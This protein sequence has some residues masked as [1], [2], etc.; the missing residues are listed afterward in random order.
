MT[1]FETVPALGK[2]DS[3]TTTVAGTVHQATPRAA[4]SGCTAWCRAPD[5]SQKGALS[6]TGNIVEIPSSVLS[7]GM[8][9]TYS[10]NLYPPLGRPRVHLPVTVGTLMRWHRRRLL[11]VAPRT[12]GPDRPAWLA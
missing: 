1:E 7:P 8:P 2:A 10:K 3:T 6:G 11:S 9:R 12:H 5:F 4:V